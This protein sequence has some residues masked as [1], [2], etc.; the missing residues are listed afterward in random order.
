MNIHSRRDF[1]KFVGK[2]S[3]WAGLFSAS[4][5]YWGRG[6]AEAAS[7]FTPSVKRDLP[8]VPLVATTQDDLILADGFHSQILISMGDSLGPGISFGVN[9]DF[10]AL[11]SLNSDGSDLVMMVNHEYPDLPHSSRKGG[12]E[13]TRAQF[14][15]EQR[16]VGVSLFRLQKKV[17]QWKVVHGDP[18]NRRIDATTP[19]PF[20]NGEKIQGLSRAKGTFGNCAGGETPWGTFLT[21]EENFDLFVGHERFENGKRIVDKSHL[22]FGWDQH[23]SS[24]PEHY[25]WVV[26]VDP[27]TGKAKKHTVLGRFAHEC[28]TVTRA[29]DGRVVVYSGDDSNNECL[30]KFVSDSSQNLQSG[31]LFVANTEQG[32]WIPLSLEDQPILR[33]SF[34]SELE[35]QIRTREAAR[36]VG[37]SPLDRPED[38][39]VDP[40]TGEVYV[41]LT[42][43]VRKTNFHGS[44]LKIVEDKNDAGAKTFQSTQ[45]YFGGA[46]AGFACPDNL[47]FDPQG[48]LWMTT[49]ISGSAID[50]GP[51]KGL[52]NNA[53]YYI[54]LKGREAGGVFRVASAPA[55]AEFTG[56]RFAPDGKSLFLSVQHP[57]EKTTSQWPTGSSPKSS[58]VAISGS[59]LEALT[60]KSRSKT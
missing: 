37:G 23:E 40:A 30:Y 5:Q 53:L 44:I 60:Q 59:A 45:A 39:E 19:I 3:V 13:F 48:N 2:T 38:I 34:Q 17:N 56:P 21:C 24:P 58:V 32:R 10:I 33:K 41:A 6:L 12:G 50:Q 26:E 4:P 54:P 42:N 25:G 20:A 51:Y 36:L 18:L 11:R 46:Q 29:K 22:A 27:I 14:L 52:G 57:G 15:R 8:F 35:L 28:A 31:T 1:L 49:D 16:E 43:N 55:E 9:N 7:F 47:T